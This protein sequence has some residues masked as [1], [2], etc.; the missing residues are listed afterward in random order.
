M[1]TVVIIGTLDT[2][3]PEH[4]FMRDCLI[5]AGVDVLLMDIGVLADSPAEA[6]FSSADVAEAAETHIETLR[7]TRE[8]SDTRA[9]ALAAMER[10]ASAI[11]AR[12]RT[13]GRCD[14]VLGAGGSGGSTVI[15]GVMRSLP[16]GMP[17]LLVSTMASGA[18]AFFGTR[19]LTIMY[20][21]TDIAGLNRVSIKVLR[22]AALA[23]AGMVSG[24]EEAQPRDRPLVAITMFGVTTPGVLRVQDR[25]QESG[26]DTIVFHANGSGGRA[27]EQMIADGLIDGVV[28]YTIS[29]LTDEHLGGVCSAGPERLT[30][31]GRLGLPQVIVPGAIEVLNF[32]PRASIPQRFD[33]PERRVIVHNANISAVRTSQGEAV[34]LARIVSSKLN[35]AKGATAVLLPLRGFDS[36]Q[37]RPD[38][39]YI[40][41]EADAAFVEELRRTLRPDISCREEALHINDPAFADAAAATFVDL[42]Q[43]H[44]KAGG[45][46]GS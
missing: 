8:G 38:G 25:L 5:G 43:E 16:V 42:W 40:D 19:D 37:Q 2:K 17:K 33:T 9:V 26:Y 23:V 15:S 44:S 41:E 35:A 18:P 12:L 34:E 10:G 22:N 21:V 20:S 45:G 11:V 13:E 6:D 29:E 28:D 24:R 39:P 46:A 30:A 14:A 4:L 32:G 3:G 7:F 36:Y 31:A 27:M 1:A